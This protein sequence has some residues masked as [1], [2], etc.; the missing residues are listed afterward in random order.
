LADPPGIG[1][2][3]ISEDVK[4]KKTNRQIPPQLPSDAKAED[5]ICKVWSLG[6]SSWVWAR[7]A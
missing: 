3:K 7:I 6:H 4:K 5:K 1:I 2:S